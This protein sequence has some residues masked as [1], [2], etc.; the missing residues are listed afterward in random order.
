M[1][2]I[3]LLLVLIG[4][5]GTGWAQTLKEATKYFEKYEYKRAAKVYEAVARNRE[6]PLDD[7]KRWAYSY[8][9]DGQYEK[10][11][12]LSDSII[13][14]Q[15]AEPM[16]YYINGEVNMGNRN[17]EK[18]KESYQHYSKLDDEFDVSV[19][20]AS[21]EQIPNW[22]REVH[23]T[24]GLMSGNSTKADINGQ[25]LEQGMIIYKE[26]G[27]DSSGVGIES[28]NI[29]NSELILARPFITSPTQNDRQIAISDS[30]M[31]DISVSSIW[32][33][34]NNEEVWLTVNK[35][36]AEDPIDLAHHL[37]TGVY[38]KEENSVSQLKLWSFGG[39]NDSSACAHAT[40]N[41]SNTVMVFTKMGPRTNGA[42]LYI[43]LRENDSWGMPKAITSLNT[44]MDEMYPMFIGDSLLSFS[45]NGRAGYGRLD[46]FIA[47]HNNGSF[48][49]IKH[50]KSPV[51]SFMDDFNFQYYDSQDSAI[52][53]SNRNS[54]IGD[55]DMYFVKFSEPYVQ[56]PVPIDSSEFTDFVNNWKVPRI[57]FD[58]NKF[59]LEEDFNKLD[60]LIVFLKKYP[61]SSIVIEGHT[62]RRGSIDYNYNLGYKRADRVAKEL[63]DAGISDGQITVKSKGKEDP[64]IDCKTCTEA[65][66][67]KNRVALILL[68]PK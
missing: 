46:I 55:D 24:N 10:C 65:D 5:A 39:Y 59:N 45:S 48:G 49:A 57:Y 67:A 60:E 29:D 66:H 56:P 25:H 44:N 19:K 26:I 16:F 58:Y 38:S 9:L 2:R 3:F 23:L 41:E 7:Y 32:L 35:P 42:D 43:S 22:D 11:L 37:Y 15:D 63:I 47:D 34:N 8:F 6:L 52:Y 4:A 21:C 68:N 28:A 17:Y 64:Q 30:A 13:N 40:V 31:N 50:M 14:T 18:A 33:E 27:R 54:G 1:R 51:N 12:P 20:I 62:D 61:K 36:L 53:T